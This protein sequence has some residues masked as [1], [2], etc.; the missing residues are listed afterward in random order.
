MES[1]KLL[2]LNLLQQVELQYKNIRNGL[3]ETLH[4]TRNYQMKLLSEFENQF[5]TLEANYQKKIQELEASHEKAMANRQTVAFK[6][7]MFKD[8]DQKLH[9][10]QRELE[11]ANKKIERLT[12]QL[13]KYEVQSRSVVSATSAAHVLTMAPIIS[14]KSI[15]LPTEQ[16][17][18]DSP[19][20]Q[21]PNLKQDHA[22]EKS[23]LNVSN[24]LEC[25]KKVDLVNE[26]VIDKLDATNKLV[27]S[28]N[29][30]LED[31]CTTTHLT[32]NDEPIVY[33]PMNE[34]STHKQDSETLSQRKGVKWKGVTY[35]YDLD[36]FLVYEQKTGGQS[37]GHKSDKKLVFDN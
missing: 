37:I 6:M 13:Q 19:S 28:P 24:D 27:E 26:T 29:K 3:D 11:Q 36:N 25:Q 14:E 12:N 32:S 1:L 21:E 18:I 20:S 33:V 7:S 4:H 9:D 15:G 10:A 17:E 2:N 16:L 23:L 22:P 30:K 5:A 8:Y 35:Y 34:E 31:V